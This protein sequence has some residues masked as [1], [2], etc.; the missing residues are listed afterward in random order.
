MYHTIHIRLKSLFLMWGECLQRS[1]TVLLF[2]PHLLLSR[3]IKFLTYGHSPRQDFKKLLCKHSRRIGI[4]A[5]LQRIWNCPYSHVWQ[6]TVARHTPSMFVCRWLSV[7]IVVISYQVYW[8][9]V[10]LHFSLRQLICQ[11][12][13]IIP[14]SYMG[15]KGLWLS[16]NREHVISWVYISFEL[17]DVVTSHIS[18]YAS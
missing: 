5:D 18:R 10:Q 3:I 14:L 17:K 6:C 12:M 9:W 11:Y 1:S 15:D 2:S 4:L 7:I 13:T 16:L 8:H